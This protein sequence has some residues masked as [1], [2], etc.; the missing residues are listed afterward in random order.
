[1]GI[2]TGSPLTGI[3]NGT[4]Q[5]DI[6]S[7]E[8]TGSAPAY[9]ALNAQLNAGNGK[10]TITLMGK[11]SASEDG[12]GIGYGTYNSTINNG[13]GDD[14]INIS[15]TAPAQTG[16]IWK[17]L[18]GGSNGTSEQGIFTTTDG[19]INDPNTVYSITDFS[20]TSS[21]FGGPIGSASDGTYI[22]PS[23]SSVPFVPSFSFN[24]NNQA[25]SPFFFLF[26][27]PISGFQY[28]TPGFQ[29][30][31]SSTEP[32]YAYPFSNFPFDVSQGGV[33]A[34]QQAVGQL[35]ATIL[36]NGFLQGSLIPSSKG[37]GVYQS[38]VDGGN[39][40]DIINI[41]GTNFGMKDS[42][43]SGG[44]GDDT[45]NVGT[46]QGTID[47]GRGVDRLVVDYFKLDA[48]NK[49]TNVIVSSDALG[50]VLISGTTDNLGNSF[51]TSGQS[52]AWT[53][54]VKGI[55]QFLVNGTAYIASQFVS[56]FG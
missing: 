3:I 43:I 31:P 42:L 40:N 41:S 18:F 47:G 51:D 54:T 35:P 27:P 4:N 32:Q 16:F 46:G 45:F 52:N 25:A 7:G 10:D 13:N 30:D 44:N 19:D 53:Q 24:S 55:E 34:L 49:P 6:F 39:G 22:Y 20:V 26:Q 28:Q 12:T 5:A 38:S 17:W 21:S 8:V 11:A 23:S 48:N 29:I 2:F 9:G 50:N 14:I 33:S 56:V 36:T 37:I 1:M 15:G